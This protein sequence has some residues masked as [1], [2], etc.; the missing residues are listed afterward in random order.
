[1][2]IT[3][4][5]VDNHLAA[6]DEKMRAVQ[7][8]TKAFLRLLSPQLHATET[9]GAAA[10]TAPSVASMPPLVDRYR[11]HRS[12]LSI[13]DDLHERLRAASAATRI[14]QSQIVAQGFFLW[15]AQLE[16]AATATPK[17]T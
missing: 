14:P 12:S 17:A 8:E 7:Y 13:T 6:W 3:W 2:T 15:L 4:K 16:S 10:S 1:M 11:P 5:D 9:D